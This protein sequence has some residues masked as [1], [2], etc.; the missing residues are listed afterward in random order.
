LPETWQGDYGE[1]LDMVHTK[2]PS[3]KV[4]LMRVWKR[5]VDANWAAEIAAIN[6]TYIPALAAAHAGWCF[7]GP[8]ERIFLEAGDDGASLTTDGIHANHDGY[9]AYASAWLATLGY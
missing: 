2:W 5:L 7:V 6:D 3:A 9:I 8:D 1:V 4:Y